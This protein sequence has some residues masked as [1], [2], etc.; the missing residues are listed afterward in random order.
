M[1]FSE[2][3][4][5]SLLLR[6][7][8]SQSILV[9][10]ATVTFF[11]ISEGQCQ[12]QENEVK[13]KAIPYG[14][15]FVN[16]VF[17]P[18]PYTVEMAGDAIVING[19]P[20][21]KH[22]AR[23]KI[24]LEPGQRSKEVKQPDA[25]TSPLSGSDE[26]QADW[27]LYIKSLVEKSGPDEAAPEVVRE[28]NRISQKNI[29]R[30]DGQSKKTIIIDEDLGGVKVPQTFFIVTPISGFT[31]I[32]P[33]A[34]ARES[35]QR[36]ME[37]IE[38]QLWKDSAVWIYNETYGIA[39]IDP[40]KRSK[41]IDV[42]RSE[43][44]PDAKRSM[45]VTD[46]VIPDHDD[47]W[48]KFVAHFSNPGALNEYFLKRTALAVPIANRGANTQKPNGEAATSIGRPEPPRNSAPDEANSSTPGR[49]VTAQPLESTGVGTQTSGVRPWKVITA[50][51]IIVGC[52]LTLF[53]I[54]R[55][56]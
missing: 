44:T 25:G 43:N 11:T 56:R 7:R 19:R 52:G 51:V 20:V 28:I 54:L 10:I 15:L 22:I 53:L 39:A 23:G 32:D 41:F 4:M 49:P 40:E 21:Q 47:L 18:G 36:Y 16:D 45:L 24:D 14:Y 8:H 33:E 42:M 26:D 30:L 12:D 35:L 46:G 6:G 37:L 27:G 38:R 3:P 50:F 1:S 9:L 2:S 55:R 17:I 31:R 13:Q 34:E 29:A 48:T 5:P